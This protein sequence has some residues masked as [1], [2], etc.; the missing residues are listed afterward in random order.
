[1]RSLPINFL[2]DPKSKIIA[3]NIRGEALDE[4]LSK[5]FGN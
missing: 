2:L 1:M 5:I 3:K 4:V